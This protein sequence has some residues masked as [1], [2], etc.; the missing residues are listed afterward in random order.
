MRLGA[1]RSAVLRAATVIA[2]IVASS[3]LACGSG[4]NQYDV[5]VRFNTSVTQDGM[6]EVS[7]VLQSFD[8]NAEM[9][10]AESFPPIGHVVLKTNAPDVCQRLTNALGAI[11]GV[12]D[13]ACEPLK[14]G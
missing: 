8:P 14:K 7:Q 10:V 9:I 2:A 1:Q 12:Q 5:T 4:T 11:A 6:D 3:A 13:V